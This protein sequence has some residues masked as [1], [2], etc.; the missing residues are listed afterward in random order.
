[1]THDYTAVYEKDPFTVSFDVDRLKNGTYK[2]K[3]EVSSENWSAACKQMQVEEGGFCFIDAELE[4]K[5]AML[6]FSGEIKT[7]MNR[8]C[9]RTLETFELEETFKFQEEVSMFD[10]EESEFMEVLQGSQLNMKDYFIQ[11]IILYMT[12]YPIHP[13]TLSVQDGEFDIKDGQE[14]RVQQEKE[15]KNPFS[16]LKGL[17]S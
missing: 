2:I 14:K 7:K 9:V 3:G 4:K 12:P 1:M 15:E 6:M 10:K 8:E 5:G 16:V 13:A 11:Q 17:K